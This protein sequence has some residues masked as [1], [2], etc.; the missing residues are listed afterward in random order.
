MQNIDNEINHINLNKIIQEE[1][2]NNRLNFNN[3]KHE[4]KLKNEQTNRSDYLVN[5]RKSKNE[6]F[7]NY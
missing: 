3:F 6:K 2:K 1:L 5:L 7:K 4:I